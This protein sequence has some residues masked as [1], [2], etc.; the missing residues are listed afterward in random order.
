LQYVNT[1]EQAADIFTKALPPQN[2]DH[3]LR[4][5]GL[6]HSAKPGHT[7]GNASDPGPEAPACVA[8]CSPCSASWA[9]PGLSERAAA[10]ALE[11]PAAACEPSEQ[12]RYA[13]SVQ[14]HLSAPVT[15]TSCTDASCHLHRHGRG[16]LR[17]QSGFL[18]LNPYPISPTICTYP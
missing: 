7:S 12:H 10:E 13:S 14:M 9:A 18:L 11:A 8:P 17:N 1:K 16:E 6:L 2:W 4:L 3:A 5:M 15:L